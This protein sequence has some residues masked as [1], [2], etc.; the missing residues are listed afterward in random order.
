MLITLRQLQYVIAVADTG[1]F[2][3]AADVCYAEQS[4]VSQQVK[5]M[6]DRLGV[7]I[8][9]RGNYPLKVTPEGQRIVEN[10]REIIDR[11]EDLIKPFKAPGKPSPAA[12]VPAR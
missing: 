6:E 2:S 7:Q 10:A 11:V 3:K 5:V 9:S 8:F 4:T 12:A 1:S